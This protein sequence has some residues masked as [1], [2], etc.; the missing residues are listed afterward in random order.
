MEWLILD[1]MVRCNTEETQLK[2]SQIETVAQ[3]RK[4]SR[5]M[6]R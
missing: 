2:L 3:V 5:G 6:V 4:I 1:M